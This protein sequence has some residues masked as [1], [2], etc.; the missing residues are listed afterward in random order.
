MYSEIELAD[1]ERRNKFYHKKEV[2]KYLISSGVP[3]SKQAM[4]RF[5]SLE[6]SDQSSKALAQSNDCLRK[7]TFEVHP[8]QINIRD[9]TS[10]QIVISISK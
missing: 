4:T 7:V 1:I 2:A 5:T 9:K 6:N 3:K 8:Q 10:G